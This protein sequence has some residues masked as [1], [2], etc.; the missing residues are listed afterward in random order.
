MAP[1][2]HRGQAVANRR[3]QRLFV[4]RCRR[5]SRQ[6]YARARKHDDGPCKEG[7][8]L[9]F[10][11]RIRARLA[12]CGK[13]HAR[14]SSDQPS[15]ACHRGG[16]GSTIAG[17]RRAGDQNARA[18]TS[19]RMCRVMPRQACRR[20]RL[21]HINRVRLNRRVRSN[22]AQKTTAVYQRG[23]QVTRQGSFGFIG[24]HHHPGLLGNRGP[25]WSQRST[26]IKN[27]AEGTTESGRAGRADKG[28]AGENCKPAA[29]TA[30]VTRRAPLL[31]S[32]PRSFLGRLQP[33]T[34]P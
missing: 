19:R 4:R 21:D 28:V 3:R 34:V 26:R 5:G 10:A 23:Q 24:N 20:S 30:W 27:C 8:L 6:H 16:L 31:Y 1:L 25:L 15:T 7:V 29:I 33:R 22:A 17:R 18:S 12:W 13:P 14:S 32:S 9:L 11:G 2:S